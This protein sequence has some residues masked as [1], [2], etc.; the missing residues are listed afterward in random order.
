MKNKP[1]FSRRIRWELDE[2]DLSRELAKRRKVGTP[3]WDL[4]SSNPTAAGIAY[5]NREILGAIQSEEALRYEPDPRGSL[6][7]REAVSRYYLERGARVPPEDLFLS[8]ST[9]EAYGFLYKLL[10]DPGDEILVPRPS[11]PLFDFLGALDA[12]KPVTYPLRFDGSWRIDFSALTAA[13]SDRS[14]LVV[15]VHPNNPTGSYVSDEDRARLLHL[16]ESRGL[17]LVV[18][19]VFLDFPLSETSKPRSF[20]GDGNGLVIVLSGLSKLAGLPQMKLGW[21]AMAGGADVRSEASLRLE[22]IADSYLSVGAPVQSAARTLLELAPR[23]RRLISERTERNLDS[24]KEQAEGA[25]SV[26]LWV[27]EGG[28]CATLRLPAVLRGEEWALALLQEE[29]VYVHP[30]SFFGFETEAVLVLSLLTPEDT[31]DEGVRR[32]LRIV[33]NRLDSLNA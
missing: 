2:N 31:F 3:V 28:W 30:G 9:S 17:A 15:A 25:Q 29:S 16:T 26:T 19:E 24:L 32:V 1:R 7:A 33:A 14:R 22:H 4:T 21:I 5:P 11:Y 13:I 10:C 27:P 20:A 12:V 18:D 8:A 23:T 6:A